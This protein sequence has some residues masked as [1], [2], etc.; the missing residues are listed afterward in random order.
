M[1]NNI[2]LKFTLERIIIN[3]GLISS[4][5]F[6]QAQESYQWSKGEILLANDAQIEGYVVYAT[7]VELVIMR[8]DDNTHKTYGSKQIKSFS[9]LD[10]RTN[11]IRHFKKSVIPQ[12]GREGIVEI[13]FEGSLQ[14]QRCFKPKYRANKRR[15]PFFNFS[16]LAHYDHSMYQYFVHDGIYLHTL[17]EFLRADFTIKK[18]KWKKQL[19]QFIRQN[20]LD[21]RVLS[22]LLIFLRFNMLES[23]PIS[24]LTSLNF[25]IVTDDALQK[26]Q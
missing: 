13:V 26:I 16:P 14:V 6:A 15:E 12:E 18:M 2:I 17:E 8:L 11:L 9:F 20:K 22:W 4:L 19:G 5:F 1:K 24:K 7:D 21:N 23:L 3:I 25:I 10:E